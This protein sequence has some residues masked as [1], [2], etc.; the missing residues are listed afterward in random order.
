MWAVVP[1]LDEMTKGNGGMTGGLSGASLPIMPEGAVTPGTRPI[2]AAVL[3]PLPLYLT[4]PPTPT[5]SLEA[6]GVKLAA[7]CTVRVKGLYK[8]CDM[9]RTNNTV[10]EQ[11]WY[12]L[13]DHTPCLFC[14]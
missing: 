13:I 12:D 3:R 5:I 4:I 6:Q 14:N 7:F 2:L 8:A 10:G 1:P 11:E 9:Q